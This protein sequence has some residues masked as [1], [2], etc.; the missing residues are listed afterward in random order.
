MEKSY[1]AQNTIIGAGIAGLTAAIELIEKGQT[2]ILIERDMPENLGGLAKE[3]FG[4]MFYIN[5]PQQKRLGIKD[6]VE[7][8][9][10]DWFSFA[11][12][13]ENE[14]WGKK[15]AE[16]YLGETHKVYEWVTQKKVKYFPV[17]HWVERGL[18]KPGNSVP[19]FHMVW[20]T[21]Y[22]L[23]DA[24]IKYLK[25]HKNYKNIQFY[26][27]H[28]AEKFELEK[29]KIISISGIYEKTG[30][31]FQCIS[32]NFIIA[33][34]GIN[35]NME[36]V[37]QNWHP[38]W[39]TPPKTILNGSH[40]FSDGLIHDE[41]NRIGGEISNLNLMWNYAAGISHPFPKRANH[42]LSLVPPKS[43]LWLNYK[44]ERIGKTPLITAFDTRYLVTEICKQDKKWSW[45][46]LNKKIVYKELSVSGSEFNSGIK[47][48][49][50]FSFLISLLFGNKELIKTLENHSEDYIVANSIEELAQKMN[51]LTDH[52]YV[53]P[54]TLKET[55][56]SYDAN[57][58]RGKNIWNDEQIRRIEHTRQY[59]GDKIRTCH[60]QKID[61][62][63]AY[64][65]V[66]IREHI[67]SRKS[68]GGIRT[69]LH[70]KV[71]TNSNKEKPTTFKN[72]YAVGE[73]AGFGGG[74]SHGKRALEGTFLAT[75]IYTAQK[76][77]EDI[78]NTSLNDEL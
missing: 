65:L 13:S 35:G 18:Y 23:V 62:P 50:I 45:Q 76:A 16:M 69:N 15:W 73:A 24:V 66:A 17:V 49:K 61:D 34:G 72:L 60:L 74:G 25:N 4:G 26:F 33:T 57:F 6:S 55:I 36:K 3:S 46:I 20:G 7:Q 71:L 22:G 44:G 40:H 54:Q 78:I 58:E 29:D 19:R 11:A 10:K 14:Y 43:A 2:V 32:D 39:N 56:N 1:K 37:K 21:G 5:S 63:K 64:P 68:L 41:V 70:S 53:N 52:E 38:E 8:A 59:R 12:F 27:Q 67:L 75:C 48:K 51:Q 42:G 30:E 28:K 47:N 9:K 31:E 77:A